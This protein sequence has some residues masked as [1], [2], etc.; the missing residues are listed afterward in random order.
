MTTAREIM[1]RADQCETNRLKWQTY[2]VEV[3]GPLVGQKVTRRF[4]TVVAKRLEADRI[5]AYVNFTGEYS[6]RLGVQGGDTGLGGNFE[7]SLYFGSSTNGR[8]IYTP[9]ERD[10]H[11]AALIAMAESCNRRRLLL[12]SA[13]PECLDEVIGDALSSLARAEEAL[14]GLP[15][16]HSIALLLPRHPV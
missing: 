3:I 1:E 8:P 2:L 10:K 16:E 5:K 12:A 9:A 4:A 13:E 6:Y 14:R 15:D 7:V 11:C